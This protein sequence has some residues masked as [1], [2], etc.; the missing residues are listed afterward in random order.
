MLIIEVCVISLRIYIIKC[1][2]WIFIEFKKMSFWNL[3]ITELNINSTITN[4]YLIFN[5][6]QSRVLHS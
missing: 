5:T 3:E 4:N 1:S 2:Y 6:I